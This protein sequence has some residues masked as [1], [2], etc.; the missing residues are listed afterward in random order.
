MGGVH[1]YYVY[2][3][4]IFYLPCP[5][6]LETFLHFGPED[7]DGLPPFLLPNVDFAELSNFAIIKV[8]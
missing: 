2:T 4:S 5:L 3:P 6:Y 1:I 7:L 8:V